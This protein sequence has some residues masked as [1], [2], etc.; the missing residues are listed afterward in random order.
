MQLMFLIHFLNFQLKINKYKYKIAGIRKKKALL[1]S[2]STLKTKKKL[3]S[4]IE[5]YQSKCWEVFL[6]VAVS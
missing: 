5:I 3:K 6:K 1:R 4:L 2:W